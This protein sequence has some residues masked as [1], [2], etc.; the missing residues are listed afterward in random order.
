VVNLQNEPYRQIEIQR[1]VND[2]GDVRVLVL[3]VHV[4]MR[5]QSCHS[6]KQ[7]VVIL[8]C[9]GELVVVFGICDSIAGVVVD[10]LGF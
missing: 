5:C 1:L 9:V 4:R 6:G 10:I 8:S 3:V 7:H 2:M